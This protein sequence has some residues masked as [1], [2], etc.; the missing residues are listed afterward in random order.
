MKFFIVRIFQELFEDPLYLALGVCKFNV[1]AD[2]EPSTS[3][4]RISIRP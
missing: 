3:E 1:T 4:L 2:N